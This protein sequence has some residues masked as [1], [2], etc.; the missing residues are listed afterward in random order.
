MAQKGEWRLWLSYWETAWHE[1]PPAKFFSPLRAIPPLVIAVL[2]FWRSKGN[3]PFKETLII[4]GIIFGIYMLFYVLETSFSVVVRCPALLDQQKNNKIG[5]LDRHRVSLEENLKSLT[6]KRDELSPKEIELL[7]AAF[8]GQPTFCNILVHSTEP[9]F[10]DAGHIRFFST[11]R[12][13]S[14]QYFEAVGSLYE[15]QWIRRPDISSPDYY[16]PTAKGLQKGRDILASAEG[17]ALIKELHK[18]FAPK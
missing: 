7:M 8:E 13:E 14:A 17:E 1:R 4:A 16:E 10:V 5:E 9:S 18:R 6:M 11:D 12:L 2:Q 15:G 3:H